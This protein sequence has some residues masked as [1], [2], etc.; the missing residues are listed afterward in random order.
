MKTRLLH[1]YN[2]AHLAHI[3]KGLLEENGIEAFIF[4]ENFMA[5]LP[6]FSGLL[7]AG[8]E[9]RVR[10]EQFEQAVAILK[11]ELEDVKKCENCGS[12]NIQF[13]YGKKGISTIIFSLFSA[14]VGEPFGN[15]ERH[16]FCND[17]GFKNKD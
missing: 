16:Y 15:I 6:S 1:K 14:I 5:T 13:T 2:Q 17:C 8:I 12:E 10:E 4:G 3:H 11:K 9:L 7:D